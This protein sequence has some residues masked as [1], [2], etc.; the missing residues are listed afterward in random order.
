MQGRVRQLSAAVGGGA[1]V[2]AAA[3]AQDAPQKWVQGTHYFLIDPPQPTESAGKVEVLEVFSYGCPHCNE[4]QPIADN[5]RKALPAGTAFRYLPAGFGRDAW[6]TFA[7]GFYAAEALGI[8]AHRLKALGLIDKIVNE[9]VGG[10][11]RDMK[12]MASHLKRALSDAVRQVTD[13]STKALLQ[14]RYE[15]LQSYGRYSDT[16]EH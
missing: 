16:K 13:L 15:R 7:R 4:F 3:A 2:A 1:K 8:T 14:R 6:T 11:H 10:A 12:W 5:I 9:P